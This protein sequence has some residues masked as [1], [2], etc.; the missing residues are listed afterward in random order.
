MNILSISFIYNLFQ[1]VVGANSFRRWFLTNFVQS[2]ETYSIL[3]IGCGTGVAASYM[4]FKSLVGIDLSAGYIASARARKLPRTKFVLGDCLEEI[5]KYQP[6]SFD[7]AL[8]GGLFHH[9]TDDQCEE[10]VLQSA[11][12][13]KPGGALYCFEPV[14]DASTPK[15]TRFVMKRDRGKNFRSVDNWRKLFAKGFPHIEIEIRQGCFRIPYDLILVC[16]RKK[17][18]V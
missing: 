17:P 2:D 9:I 12:V 13:L 14:Y 16:A 6:G 10:L 3:D 1:D 4:K 5:Q 18:K 8:C 11:R 7:I 15:L